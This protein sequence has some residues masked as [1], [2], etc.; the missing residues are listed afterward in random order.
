[1]RWVGWRQ[2]RTE[3]LIAA[4]IL[5]LLAALLIP[6]GIEM[7]NAYHHD[8]LSVCL[9][10]NTSGTCDQ[11][12]QAFTSRFESIGN[13]ASWLTLTPGLVGALLAAPF[14]LD[15]ENGTYRLAWTQSIT[16]SRWIA[17]KLGITI[18]AALLFALA[19]AVLATWWRAPLVHLNGRMDNSAFDSQGTVVFGYA[20]FALGLA[21]AVGVVS[22][23]T[24]PALIVA[25]A[26]Y[27]A[28][29]IF[30]DTWLRQR[31]ETPVSATWRAA[32]PGP[33]GPSRIASAGPANLN[34]AWVLNE[35]PSD[36][37]GHSTLGPCVR[38]VASGVRAINGN[39]LA[40]HGAGYSH[41]VYQPASRFWLFQ[42]IE[43]AIFGGLALL[44]IAFAA[45]W[46]HQRTA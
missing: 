40:R 26:G 9:G 39:C 42:G 25:F 45:W 8:G 15:L 2:Q 11:A 29:R 18:G 27:V 6:T 1:V 7:A 46:T 20:L 23:R 5:A 19:M 14:V 3:T 44:L 35:Y 10:Q 16:R 4:A 37:L 34:H 36:K 22:R 38:A 13:L 17:T 32:F 43:T 30:V 33:G 21:L 31:F 41:A 28:A 12:M 24:V